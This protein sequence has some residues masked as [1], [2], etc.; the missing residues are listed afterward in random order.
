L[1]GI[2]QDP[3]IK[4]KLAEAL[5][6]ASSSVP[7]IPARMPPPSGYRPVR[8]TPVGRLAPLPE[9]AILS[10]LTILQKKVKDQGEEDTSSDSDNYLSPDPISEDIYFAVERGEDEAE[11]PV[12]RNT[13]LPHCKQVSMPETPDIPHNFFPRKGSLPENRRENNPSFAARGKNEDQELYMP[14]DRKPRVAPPQLPKTAKPSFAENLVNQSGGNSA[15]S[16]AARHLAEVLQSR[17]NLG[18]PPSLRPTKPK[19]KP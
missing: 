9:A 19:P 17:M 15:S 13:L 16:Q 14:M 7:P 3:T 10:P 6:N 12:A 2:E 8:Q 11:E 1:Y 18:E 5:E 4:E